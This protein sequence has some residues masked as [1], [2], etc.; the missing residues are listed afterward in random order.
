MLIVT[1]GVKTSEYFSADKVLASTIIN[2]SF[3]MLEF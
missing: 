3:L 1:C 2:P